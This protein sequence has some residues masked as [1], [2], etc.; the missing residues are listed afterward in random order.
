MTQQNAFKSEDSNYKKKLFYDNGIR[1][2]E[3]KG[4]IISDYKPPSPNLKTQVNQTLASSAGLVGNGTSHYNS[5]IT[6]LFYSKKEFADW[7]QFIGAEHR[8]YDEKGTIY[9]GLVT[10]EPD[11][12]TVEMETKY[13][14]TVGLA[15]VRKQD[16]EYRY[17]NQ[18]IDIEDHWAKSYI[19]EMQ[20]RGLISNYSSDGE[21]V[22]YFRPDKVTTRAEGITFLMRS[23]RYID[24]ILRGY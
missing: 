3:V 16:H 1:F 10:G 20:Q 24:R 14:V 18:F 8:F 21:S 2:T 22:A 5:T 23:Y 11:I 15:L 13:M 7:L 19:D 12:K 9:V 17:E 4:R 6:L